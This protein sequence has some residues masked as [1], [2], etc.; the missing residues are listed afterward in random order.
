MKNRIPVD[1]EF[2]LESVL[3]E[4]PDKIII[5]NI[6]KEKFDKLGIPS[7]IGTTYHYNVDARAF[8]LAKDKVIIY[9]GSPTTHGRME[10][11]LRSIVFYAKSKEL[12]ERNAKFVQD[13]NGVG[14]KSNVNGGI[15]YFYGLQLND[16]EDVRKYLYK[17]NSYF[18]NL[19]IRGADADK[20]S[21]ELA[22]RVWLDKNAI[23]FWNSKD[24]WEK[25]MKEVFDFM[26]F[27]NMNPKKAIYE[28][29]DSRNFWTYG[30][31]SGEEPETEKE[32]L[33]PEEI[34]KLQAAQHLDA[35]AKGKLFGPEYKDV[36][37]QKAA[38][39]FDYPAQATAAVPALESV[40]KL[41]DLLQENP[42]AVYDI[43]DSET[44]EGEELATWFDN[45]AVAFIAGDGFSI[46]NEGGVHYDI[47]DT[48]YFIYKNR[49]QLTDAM[50]YR[51]IQSS[52]M[53]V[54]NVEKLKTALDSGDLQKYM[55]AGGRRGMGGDRY[56]NI[57]GLVIGRLWKKK[58]ILSFWNKT[59]YVLQNWNI[60]KEMFGNL[61]IGNLDEYQIDWYERGAH[62]SDPLTPA[63][64][65]SSGKI[66]KKSEPA[67]SDFIE[68]LFSDPK[69][70]GK[71]T[72]AQQKKASDVIH[73]LP[74]EK[75]RQKLMAM[76]Y[77]NIKAIEIA[78]ALGMTVAEFNHL[79][80]INESDISGLK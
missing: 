27:M 39:G 33:S 15:V 10:N 67:Q 75:K 29:I 49:E 6:D 21:V 58:K 20:E 55:Y 60:V 11:T 16:L 80:N 2:L 3:S 47:I 65:V 42:D 57:D 28:F 12:F 72:S 68:K 74:A 41:K 5:S 79:M 38:K 62:S 66:T 37:K 18:R 71:L 56:R 14:V 26:E 69:S 48:M 53:I 8:F 22:G 52:G 1:I 7:Q 61:D 34:K 59:P 30:E 50:I 46:L 70:V 19:E 9:N 63:S 23:S 36:H 73:L 32:K 77:K 44:K 17:H 31:L 78:D 51:K 13:E 64:D 4:T 24:E 25:Y 54:D 40:I 45:D 43:V 76:G 35:K